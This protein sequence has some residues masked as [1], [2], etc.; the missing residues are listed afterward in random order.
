[1]KYRPGKTNVAA[2]VLSRMPDIFQATAAS[3]SAQHNDTVPWIMCLPTSAEAVDMDQQPADSNG[4]TLK[5]ITSK[6]VLQAQ[7]SD[8]VIAPA[9]RFKAKGE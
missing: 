4:P 5:T 9:L 7:Q 6:D 3:M 8:P 2:D 1:M